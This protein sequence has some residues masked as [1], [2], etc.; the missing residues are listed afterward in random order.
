MLAVG[1]SKNKIQESM[2][3]DRVT[4]YRIERE[5]AKDI[6]EFRAYQAKNVE[7]AYSMVSDALLAKA[8]RMSESKGTFDDKE[9][10]ALKETSVSFGLL[11]GTA[12]RLRGGADV[13]IEHRKAKTPEQLAT[14]LKEMFEEE[15]IDV[16]P[17]ED[18]DG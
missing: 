6:E 10:K 1:T 7:I 18:D 11:E 8:E 14:E 13:V 16:T 15:V 3:C 2:S 9:A 5:I 4:I 17:K 12:K